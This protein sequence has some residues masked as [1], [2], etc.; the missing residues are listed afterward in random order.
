VAEALKGVAP[1]A[2]GDGSA[3]NP[4]PTGVMAGAAL[5]SSMLAAQPPSITHATINTRLM[6]LPRRWK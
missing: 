3:L 1:A 4:D 6:D 2:T 5:K